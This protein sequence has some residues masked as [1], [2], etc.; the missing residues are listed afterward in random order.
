MTI[1][2][3]LGM[4]EIGEEAHWFKV[5]HGDQ[6]QAMSIDYYIDLFQ[7]LKDDGWTTVAYSDTDGWVA[8]RTLYAVVPRP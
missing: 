2:T 3:K 6:F 7:S 1:P 5:D 8:Y 4:Q